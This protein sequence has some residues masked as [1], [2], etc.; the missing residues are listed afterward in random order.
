MTLDQLT[1]GDEARVLDIRAGR[2]LQQ[3]LN[4]LGIHLGDTVCISGCGAFR[5][6]FLVRV[7]GMQIAL[8][9]GIARHIF[10][11]PVGGSTSPLPNGRRFGRH[12]RRRGRSR[13]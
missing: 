9:R 11:E 10:V 3:R 5:G 6:P 8:G 1:P 13:R 4:H 7:H 2:G 12:N